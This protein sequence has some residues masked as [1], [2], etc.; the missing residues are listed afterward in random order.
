LRRRDARHRGESG[1]NAA[2]AQKLTAQKLHG[3]P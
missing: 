1:R 3:P 2:Q